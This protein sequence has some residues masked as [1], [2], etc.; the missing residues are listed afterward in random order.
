MGLYHTLASV[1]RE[2]VA[3]YWVDLTVFANVSDIRS[4]K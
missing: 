1:R 3:P 2:E 4:N